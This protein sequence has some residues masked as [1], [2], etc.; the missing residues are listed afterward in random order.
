MIK[1]ILIATG[2]LASSFT[3]AAQN[4]VMD[5]QMTDYRGNQG[6]SDVW[7]RER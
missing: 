6:E 5:S 7:A 2:L 1:P 4:Y 3:F